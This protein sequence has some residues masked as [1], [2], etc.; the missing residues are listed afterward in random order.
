MEFEVGV[1]STVILAESEL[2]A[3]QLHDLARSSGV[4]E[5]IKSIT[6][7]PTGYILARLIGTFEPAV[8]LVDLQ[9]G[10]VAFE[11]GAEIRQRIPK[12]VVFGMNAHPGHIAMAQ[13][14]GYSA[15]LPPG[16]SGDDV[17]IELREALHRIL[18]GVEQ[19]LYSF[20]PSKAGSGA[21]TIVFNTACA[22]ARDRSRRV[23]VIDGDLRSGVQALLLNATPQG[24]VENLLTQAQAIDTF[25]WDS[26]IYRA[27]GVDFLL[28]GRRLDL[29]L[30]AWEHWFQVINFAK[31][32]YDVILVD[33]PEVVND[34]T[35]EI[36][37]RSRMVFTVATTEVLSLKLTQQRLMELRRWEIAEE[38]I[39][40]MVNRHHPNDPVAKELADALGR[41]VFKSIPN[42]YPVFRTAVL[43]GAPVLP[44][45]KP[46]KVFSELAAA[47][48][49]TGPVTANSVPTGWTGKLRG[50]LKMP[51]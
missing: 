47:L 29:P 41:P 27:H 35:V 49:S 11:V 36:V 16:A 31:D 24:T 5:I 9:S 21:S 22:I 40:L 37:R 7:M 1:F 13:Q 3:R 42:N 45:S 30:P 39:A 18:G 43:E 6:P 17:R 33:L 10:S 4:L 46:G 12:T 8:V 15:L 25:L 26:C 48:D 19:N 50:L 23:L 51:A 34:A 14:A 38:R 44:V 2:A 20:I 28:S 32:R